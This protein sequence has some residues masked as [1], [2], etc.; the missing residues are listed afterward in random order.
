ML[1]MLKNYKN[2]NN[3]PCLKE[4]TL[5]SKMQIIKIVLYQSVNIV[6]IKIKCAFVI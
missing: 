6:I 1:G 2:F 5:L 3:H 4:T